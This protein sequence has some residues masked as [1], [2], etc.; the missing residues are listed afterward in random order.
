[1]DQKIYDPPNVAGWPG[2]RYWISTNTY[3]RRREFAR[4]VIDAMS[5]VRAMQLITEMPNY[6]DVTSFVANIAKYL[7]PV[8][9]NETRLAYYKTTLLEGQPDY[10]WSEKLKQ[11]ASA[12]RSLR[13]LLKTIAVAPD[14]QLC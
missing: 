5:D 13:S 10:T 11:P 12:A 2:Y 7:L 8:P 3:P 4:K 6:E 9:V 14:F 1:M